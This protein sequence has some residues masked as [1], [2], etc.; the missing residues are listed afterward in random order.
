[1]LKKKK[2]KK[3][4]KHTYKEAVFSHGLSPSRTKSVSMEGGLLGLPGEETPVIRLS[5]S[6]EK[7]LFLC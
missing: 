6:T 4:C 7:N 2:K 1:M 3:N 5:L